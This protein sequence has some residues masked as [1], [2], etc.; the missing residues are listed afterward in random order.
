MSMKSRPSRGSRQHL[1]PLFMICLAAQAIPA[2]ATAA[3]PP[4]PRWSDA[5]ELAEECP[6]TLGTLP[7]VGARRYDDPA[8]GI[9]ASYRNGDETATMYFYTGGQDDIPDDAEVGIVRA[10]FEA[11]CGD[12]EEACKAGVYAR[13]QL[14]ERDLE[15]VA[16]PWRDVKFHHAVFEI[17]ALANGDEPPARSV[18]HLYLGTMRGVFVKLRHTY[19]A[20]TGTNQP[21]SSLAPAMALAIYG[22]DLVLD[23]DNEAEYRRTEPYVRPVG[24][25]LADNP[26]YPPDDLSREMV[27]FLSR[28]FIGTPYVKI[29]LDPG[30]LLP[31]MERQ[32]C[33]CSEFVNAMYLFGCGLHLLEQPAATP[34]DV[35]LGATQYMLRAYR[36]LVADNGGEVTCEGLAPVLEAETAGSLAAFLGN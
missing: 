6:T 14:T 31:L 17:E 29:N 12:I 11:S 32:A 34:G 9:S 24:R 16:L 10:E 2:A 3:D 4:S 5:P 26:R 28:W 8:N 33:D 25:W 21:P 35:R 7:F 22:T 18:S 13:A 23:G 27:R 19:P 20:G 15:T 30:P 36:K 1:V